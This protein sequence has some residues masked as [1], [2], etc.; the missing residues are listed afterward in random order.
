MN[1]KIRKL[2]N[3]FVLVVLLITIGILFTQALGLSA[4]GFTDA[5]V[6][7][8]YYFYTT[9]TI[10]FAVGILIIYG[11]QL[12]IT[13]DDRYGN[14]VSF[15]SPNETPGISVG[16]FKN[17]FKL[18]L[19]SA[20]VFSVL[21][22][23]I[24]YFTGETFFGTDVAVLKQQFTI[25]SSTTF[26]SALVPI[27]E[28]LTVAFVWALFLFGFRTLAKKKSM[29]ISTFKMFAILAAPILFGIFGIVYHLLRYSASDISIFGVFFFW[30]VGGIITVL[31]GSFIPFWV[32]HI[33]NNLFLDLQKY[34]SNDAVLI[35][36]GVTLVLASLFYIVLAVMKKKN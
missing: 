17:Q 5:A 16:I 15:I 7:S 3:H 24:P 13:G 26:S 21:F 29:G 18:F 20:I 4:K 6:L 31:S 28:N 8:Q 34:F 19:L 35:V 25:Y 11:I 27:S 9:A 23:I 14:S 22:G 10:A 36:A 2:L 1:E 33:S 12:L 32:M 30:S